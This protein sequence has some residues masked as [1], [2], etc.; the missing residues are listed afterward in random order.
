MTP[1]FVSFLAECP[2]CHK[3]TVWREHSTQTFA[4]TSSQTIEYL[5]GCCNQ[6]QDIDVQTEDMLA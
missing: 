1:A 2:N 4:G 3:L 5:F 6:A